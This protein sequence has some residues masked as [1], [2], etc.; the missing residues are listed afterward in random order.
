MECS[1]APAQTV[2]I[3]SSMLSAL[4]T[5]GSVCLR[6]S[7]DPK[8]ESSRPYRVNCFC[9]VPAT[10][11]LCAVCCAHGLASDA[12]LPSAREHAAHSFS[13]A[14]LLVGER[15][16]FMARFI[17]R[18]RDVGRYS[19]ARRRVSSSRRRALPLLRR[20]D[21]CCFSCTSPRYSHS[22]QS[23]SDLLHSRLHRV[24]RSVQRTR[25]CTTRTLQYRRRSRL[26]ACTSETVPLFMLFISLSE[27]PCLTHDKHPALPTVPDTS[28]SAMPFLFHDMFVAKNTR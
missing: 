26:L 19:F 16:A 18:Q 10:S 2:S 5:L 11:C 1:L 14:L 12:V 21:N 9:K 28:F 25:Q 22:S 24:S 27:Q 4:C 3:S 7:C 17:S 8:S 23:I 20:I 15:E 6:G 13:A